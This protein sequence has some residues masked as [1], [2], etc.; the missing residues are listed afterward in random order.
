M[1]CTIYDMEAK[2]LPTQLFTCAFRSICRGKKIT[3]F[4]SCLSLNSSSQKKR[5]LVKLLTPYLM[6]G[7]RPLV[8][9]RFMDDASCS[10][11]H[12]R[13]A[14]R[15]GRYRSGFWPLRSC[16]LSLAM[17]EFRVA[18]SE[19]CSSRRQACGCSK[20]RLQGCCSKAAG[21]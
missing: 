6:I 3:G 7:G 10:A 21:S 9:H 2:V 19:R 17:V 1:L 4:L 8:A 18:G 11:G 16:A 15:A 13:P 12:L 5:S 20:L 14:G